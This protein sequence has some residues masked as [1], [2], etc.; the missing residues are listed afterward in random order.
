MVVIRVKS[1]GG[2]KKRG[3]SFPWGGLSSGKEGA[4]GRAGESKRPREDS[5]EGAGGDST[6]FNPSLPLTFWGW[7]GRDGR[8]E[9]E[10]AAAGGVNP[11][12]QTW[13]KV[14]GY[15]ESNRSAAGAAGV[16]PVPVVEGSRS[17]WAGRTA[18]AP[19]GGNGGRGL[20]G[21]GLRG[22]NGSGVEGSG[23]IEDARPSPLCL[24][25]KAPG[26]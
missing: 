24:S 1:G 25:P 6:P 3:S 18:A 2:G 4:G 11:G 20:V 8:E 14:G 19:F 26:S 5:G 22:W 23:P 13:Q 12:V 16:G 17:Q 9:G 10:V 21:R 15:W 7:A